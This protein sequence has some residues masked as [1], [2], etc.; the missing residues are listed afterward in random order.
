MTNEKLKD[1]IIPKEEVLI[2]V[3]L[4]L[5]GKGLELLKGKS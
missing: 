3:T 4:F 2:T 5:L 1:I